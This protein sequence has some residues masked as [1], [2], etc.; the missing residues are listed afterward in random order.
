MSNTLKQPIAIVVDNDEANSYIAE[1]YIND[2]FDVITVTSPTMCL[3]L[4][5]NKEISLIICSTQFSN[6]NNDL[7]NLFR[8]PQLSCFFQF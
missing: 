8:T 5:K 1:N 6:Y 7:V 3:D 4:I 2:Y